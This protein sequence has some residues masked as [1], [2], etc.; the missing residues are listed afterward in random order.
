MSL[1]SVRDFYKQ[2]V[3][4]DDFRNQVQNVENKEECS[5]IVK[6]AGYDFTQEEYEEYTLKLLES[7]NSD[8]ELQDLGEKELAAVFGGITGAKLRRIQAQPLYGVIRPPIQ[9]LYGVIIDNT[10]I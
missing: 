3:A 5:Q 4:D 10:R 1:G 6:A 2:L 7:A 8:N 9:L